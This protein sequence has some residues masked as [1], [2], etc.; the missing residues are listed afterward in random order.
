MLD[1]DSAIAKALSFLKLGIK[2]EQVK[3]IK[4]LSQGYDL[5]LQALIRVLCWWSLCMMDQL[6][7]KPDSLQRFK[8]YVMLKTCY[9]SGIGSGVAPGAGTAGTTPYFRVAIINYA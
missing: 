6:S 9:T 4:L 3:A 7:P 2:S 8:K 1:I 5:N